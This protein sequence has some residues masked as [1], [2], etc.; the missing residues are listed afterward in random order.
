MGRP[1][2]RKN[3][4]QKA[5]WLAVLATAEDKGYDGY[6]SLLLSRGV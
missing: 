2:N 1:F 4:L 6:F 3:Y 5:R